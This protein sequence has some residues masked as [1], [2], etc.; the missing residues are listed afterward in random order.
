MGEEQELE[1]MVIPH[2]LQV[3]VNSLLL[4]QAGLSSFFFEA[5]EEIVMQLMPSLVKI[6]YFHF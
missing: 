2:W 6:I 1:V 3:M 5:A 4:G